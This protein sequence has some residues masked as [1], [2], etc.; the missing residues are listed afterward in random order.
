MG[1]WTRRPASVG[2][3]APPGLGLGEHLTGIDRVRVC[4]AAVVGT[5]AI[6]LPELVDEVSEDRGGEVDLHLRFPETHVIADV[7]P[8]G[9]LRSEERRVGKEC[10]GGW[11]ADKERREVGGGRVSV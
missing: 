2:E 4:G 3:D 10:R 7:G 9:D 5:D 6:E 8:I 11:A 1:A